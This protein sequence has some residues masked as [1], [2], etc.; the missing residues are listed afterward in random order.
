MNNELLAVDDPASIELVRLRTFDGLT[1]FEAV[2]RIG[3]SIRT[4][5]R[6]WTYARAWLSDKIKKT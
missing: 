5:D 1:I 6:H 2:E 3:I 4:A